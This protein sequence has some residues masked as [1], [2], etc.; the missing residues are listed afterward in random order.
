MDI[1][2]KLS[3]LEYC[4]VTESIANGFFTSPADGEDAETFVANYI[5][6][7]GR[8]NAMRIFYNVCVIKS[9][10]DETV[11]HNVGENFSVLNPVFEDEGFI[12]AYTNGSSVDKEGF[13]LNFACALQDAMEIVANR[14]ERYNSGVIY[15]QKIIKKIKSIFGDLFSEENIGYLSE[16][17]DKFTN[18]EITSDK[19][20]DSIADAYGNSEAFNKVVNS[21]THNGKVV[22]K[23]PASE[24]AKE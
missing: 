13:G 16:I 18:G 1:N 23:T 4:V 20:A 12:S 10:F 2:T 7:Y 24:E 19:I 21:S 6:H 17:A 3:L 14:K 22:T 9:K 15:L 5:P 8:L 11:P